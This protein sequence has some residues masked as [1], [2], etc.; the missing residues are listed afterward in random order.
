MKVT[1][2]PG[3]GEKQLKKIL[4][5]LKQR[6]VQVGWFPSSRYPT[7]VPVAYVATIHVFGYPE[8]NIPARDFMRPTITQRTPVWKAT[9]ATGAKAVVKGSNT[10]DGVLNMIGSL[11]SAD[12]R[13]AITQLTSPAL[14]ESTIKARVSRRADKRTIGLLTKPL[15]DTKYMIT[16]LTY[17]IT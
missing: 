12:I 3:P 2:K 5:E 14:Q 15:V 17:S 9:L 13:K 16:S 8:K 11:A 10:L 1:R 4:E 6:E 7:G